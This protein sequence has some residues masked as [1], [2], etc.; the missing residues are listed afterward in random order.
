MGSGRDAQGPSGAEIG[1][2]SDRF[3]IVVELLIAVVGPVGYPYV[4]APINL[5]TVRQVEFA[6]LLPC[7]LAADL[8]DEA[9]VLVVLHDAIVA[10]AI[11]DEDVALRI[12]ADIARAA[13]DVL[14]RRRIRTRRRYHGAIDRRW[15]AADHHQHLA[16][17]AELGDEIRAFVH[18]PDVVVLVDADRVREFEAVIALADFLDELAGLVE[19]EQAR[20][21][22]AM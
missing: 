9:A 17:R 12:E 16:L 7:L 20:R 21:V 8:R 10:V 5:E 13:E 22:A 3:Q 2:L 11:C 15:P 19:F 18:R 1:D 6:E 14:L 4:T